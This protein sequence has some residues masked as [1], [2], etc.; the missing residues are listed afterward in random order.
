MSV[1]ALHNET[2]LLSRFLPLHQGNAG[3]AQTDGG[4]HIAL[5]RAADDRIAADPRTARLGDIGNLY[6]CA[7]RLQCLLLCILRGF[8]DALNAVTAKAYAARCFRTHTALS[9]CGCRLRHIGRQH[10]LRRQKHR[11]QTGQCSAAK[12]IHVRSSLSLL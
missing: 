11:T 9:R 6:G 3:A 4:I 7:A 5:L 10:R 12:S 1:T 8:A 2:E